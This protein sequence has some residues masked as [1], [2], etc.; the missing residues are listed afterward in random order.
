MHISSFI[1]ASVLAV[2]NA[3][4]KVN[5]Y[6]NSG[7]SN[8][9]QSI[10]PSA[11]GVCVSIPNGSNANSMNI[12]NCSSLGGKQ[13]I[14]T[15]YEKA[16]CRGKGIGAGSRSSNCAANSGRFASLQCRLI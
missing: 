9:I 3:E 2:A 4:F 1:L 11:N 15:F 14:C 12:A 16:N 8:F 7:C 10:F 6:S 13:C 5:I